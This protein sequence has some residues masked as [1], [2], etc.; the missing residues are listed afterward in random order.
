MV[1]TLYHA[2][3]SLLCRLRMVLSLDKLSAAQVCAES[4]ASLSQPWTLS[5]RRT[6]GR[7]QCPTPRSSRRVTSYGSP[8]TWLASPSSPSYRASNLS[9]TIRCLGM[10]FKAC[11]VDR[12]WRCA[13]K[14]A[15]HELA[16]VNAAAGRSP[17][18]APCTNGLWVTQPSGGLAWAPPAGG[19]SR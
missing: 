10:Y 19:S 16:L 1:L 3:S 8:W 14:T 11:W 9:T 18:P 5:E 6:H 2:P 15:I 12:L 7:S 13:L 4:L 17:R